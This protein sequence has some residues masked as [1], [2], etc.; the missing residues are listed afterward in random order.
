MIL[1]CSLDRLE[2]CFLQICPQPFCV[3]GEL[4]EWGCNRRSMGHEL[5]DIINHS[6]ELLQFF[7]VIWS[8]P[9]HNASNFFWC[10]MDAF[11]V[12][13]MAQDVKFSSKEYT[14]L[15]VCIELVIPQLS[16]CMLDVFDVLFKAITEDK[17]IV[18]VN[19]NEFA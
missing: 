19:P 4:C 8:R 14:F 13:H 15:W 1:S 6:I 18:N 5:R 17:N 10:W 11:I 7:L 2:S 9:I 16:A 3:P 12:Y